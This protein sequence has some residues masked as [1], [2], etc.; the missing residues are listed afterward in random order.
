MSLQ[1]HSWIG[2]SEDPLSETL[3]EKNL[4]CR[5]SLSNLIQGSHCSV[6]STRTPGRGSIAQALN[7]NDVGAV[8]NY[9]TQVA[10][11]AEASFSTKLLKQI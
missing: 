8:V 10:L 11:Q 9:H 6:Y 5:Y 4:G 2:L 3:N 1:H 7:G